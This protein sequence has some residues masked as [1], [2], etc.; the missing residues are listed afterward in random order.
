MQST[1]AKRAPEGDGS[2][3][4]AIQALEF[5][6]IV[7]HFPSGVTVVTTC[8]PGGGPCG[9]TVNA[10]SSVSLE[11]PLV[12]ICVERN[13]AS[14]ACI[15]SVG[16]F[17]VNVLDADEGERLS[18]RFAEP[19]LDDKFEGIGYGRGGTGAPILDE[20]LAWMECRV[21]EEFEGGDHTIFLGE[22]ISGE[23]REG[24]PLVYYRGG[25]GRFDS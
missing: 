2:P 14:H 16:M 11:P 1:N 22:V 25:Y 4:Q 8:L 10:F 17:A 20:A 24:H 6:R 3:A 18:R 13:A 5:R 21:S 19:L 23:T 15:R 7:G 12:L 9:L